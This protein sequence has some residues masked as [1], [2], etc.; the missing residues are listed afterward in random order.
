MDG[1]PLLTVGCLSFHDAAESVLAIRD[2]YGLSVNKQH[3]L[4]ARLF[5]GARQVTLRLILSQVQKEAKHKTQEISSQWNSQSR[6][7]QVG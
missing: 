3:F 2:G 4:L 7:D 6:A 1:C 5:P